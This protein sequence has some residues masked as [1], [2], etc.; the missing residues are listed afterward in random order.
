MSW[1]WTFGQVPEVSCQQLNEAII[2][3]EALVIDVR[4]ASEWSAGRVKG[5]VNASFLP[6]WSFEERVM[7]L[8]KGH[9]YDKEIYVICLSAH[10]S[11]G[12]LK[13]LRGRGYSNVKQLAR[14]MQEWRKQKMEEER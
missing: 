7:P 13:F 6:P 4:T 11:I 3:G 12:A 9:P 10:R 2:R 1:L 5:A 14:G 8:V